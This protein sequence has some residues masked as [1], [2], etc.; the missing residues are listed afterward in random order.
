MASGLLHLKKGRFRPCFRIA[1]LSAAFAAPAGRTV[2][3]QDPG[4]PRPASYAAHAITEQI[5]I[6]GVMTESDWQQADSIAL[7]WEF[8]PGNNVTPPVETYCRIAYDPINLYLGCVALDP[9]PDEIRAHLAERD[10]RARVILDDHVIFLIDPFNEERRGF[11]F[12]INAAGVQMD[13]I[14]S[15]AEGFEDFSWN[16]IWSSAA[17][18]TSTGWEVEAA[19]P[20]SSLRFPGSDGGEQTWAFVIERSYPRSVR[21]RMRSAA[22]DQNS[23]CVLCQANAVTGFRGI[24]SGS[25]VEVVPT[26][27]ARR[28]DVRTPFPGGDFEPTV[29]TDL[30]DVDP[31]LGIDLRW[32]VTPNW[33]LNGTFNPDFSQVE[34]D[35]AQLAVNRRFALFFPERR[36]F[37]LEG[38]DF[39][40]TP[41]QTVFTRTITNP[42]GGV[43]LSGNE[44]GHSGGAF[45]VRDASTSFLFPSNQGSTSDILDQETTAG[46]ARYRRDIGETSYVGALYTGRAGSGYD[47]HVY[48]IDALGQ[49]SGSNTL[50]VQYVRSSTDYPDALA[51]THAQP[52]G[53]F[54]GGAFS[55]QFAHFSRSW[56]ISARYDD[57]TPD[58]R[59]DLG[60]IPRVDMRTGSGSVARV[61]WGQPDAWYARLRL[62]A[63][64]SRTE[65]YDG[66][67]SDDVLGA[68]VTYEGAR[69]ST[70]TVTP[71]R[72]TM[73]VRGTSHDLNRLEGSFQIRP[74]GSVTLLGAVRSGDFVDFVNNRKSF[75][76]SLTPTV[77]LNLGRALAIDLGHVYQRLTFDG[78]RVFTANLTQTRLL[79]H[80][81]VRTFVRAILQYRQVDRD[82][83]QYSSSVVPK[84]EQFFTQFLA[85]YKVN[86]QTAVFVGY[87][88]DHFGT[89]EFSLQRRER[90]FF[91]K[92]GYAFHR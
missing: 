1:L 47:N 27:T 78:S 91:L 77:Q 61:F 89:D 86:P 37:F 69:Q 7:S 56:L 11:Q 79:Y 38:A 25:N 85:S 51:E 83:T 9:R 63:N 36:P 34:A 45:V 58:F 2:S 21:H 41:L 88:D 62:G 44:S 84:T 13:A 39:F 17:Q 54:S 33:S 42:D 64:Y 22:V 28:T 8:L 74:S 57:L 18:V 3:A 70:V 30:A 90:T 16:T 59:A 49:F 40:L 46:V 53:R 35:V 10:D 80:F 31:D 12:R 68:E 23:T 32:G 48:G 43:K 71:S 6:D 87:T 20:F 14:L 4:L 66:V 29:S 52:A 50:R 75:G 82:A 24:S 73:V 67:L 26:V 19:I 15:K 92:F 60:F 72:R 65:D 76:L 5:Q 55:A 81:N